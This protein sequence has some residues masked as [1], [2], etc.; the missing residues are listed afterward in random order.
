[1][2]QKQITA[3]SVWLLEINLT[4]SYYEAVGKPIRS[5][6]H[7]RTKMGTYTNTRKVHETQPKLF[8]RT[9]VFVTDSRMRMPFKK[10]FINLFFD[11]QFVNPIRQ[12]L[13][14]NSTLVLTG[15]KRIQS[16]IQ[17]PNRV[18]TKCAMKLYIPNGRGGNSNQN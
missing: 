17:F 12:P 8:H 10:L 16:T 6:L 3:T 18:I 9:L 11:P 5:P 1:V 4:C 2:I 13:Q 15:N 14:S 7:V